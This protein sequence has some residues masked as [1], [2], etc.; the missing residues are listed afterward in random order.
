MKVAQHLPV[1]FLLTSNEPLGQVVKG[2]VNAGKFEDVGDTI[3][4]EAP[5]ENLHEVASH[6]YGVRRHTGSKIGSHVPQE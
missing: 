4:P 5:T 6:R 2:P 3:N 1:T